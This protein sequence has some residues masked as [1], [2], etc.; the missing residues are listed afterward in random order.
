MD[1]SIYTASTK[2][3]TICSIDNGICALLCNVTLYYYYSI[4]TV[5]KRHEN[6][7]FAATA[8]D[9][10]SNEKWC[11]VSTTLAI[12]KLRRRYTTKHGE[13]SRRLLHSLK[14]YENQC[15]NHLSSTNKWSTRPHTN[16]CFSSLL[17]V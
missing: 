17:N 8:G 14:Q 2:Q 15:K 5:F 16:H 9:T 6:L 7:H 11:A 1:G 12:I 3:T 13:V 4:V 10:N